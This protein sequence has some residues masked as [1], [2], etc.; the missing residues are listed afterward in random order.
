M[1]APDRA[2]EMDALWEASQGLSGID[3]GQEAGEPLLPHPAHYAEWFSYFDS[4]DL[5]RMLSEIEVV[6][7]Q[8]AL[9]HNNGMVSQAAD[10]LKLGALL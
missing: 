8:A 1:K 7:I 6:L 2:E 4:I 3:M 5:R 9:Q 10:T